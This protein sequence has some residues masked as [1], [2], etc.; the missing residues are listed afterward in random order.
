MHRRAVGIL[1]ISLSLAAVI[2][3]GCGQDEGDK[4]VARVGRVN[5]T[6]KELRQKLAE[7][8]PFTRQQFQGPEGTIDF[9][10]RLVDE[11]VLYQA[12]VKAGYEDD[13]EVKRTLEAIKRRS[14][15]QAYYKGEIES[16]VEVPEEDV[17]AYYDEHDEQFQREARI[18]FRHI[19]A[20]TRSQ[21]EEGRRRV[22]AGEDFASVARDMSTDGGSREAGGLMKSVNVGSALPSAGMDEDFIR[23]VYEDWRVGQVTE[24]LR[25]GNGW[26][27]V[28]LEERLEAGKKPLDEV[29]DNIVQSLM[30][31]KTREYYDSV[32]VEL[33]EQ[34]GAKVNED[35]FRTK[36]RTEEELFTLAQD[37]DDPLER[38]NYYSELVFNYPDGAHAAEAQF[39]IGF[40]HAEELQN[41]AAA[42]NAFRRVMDE[43]PDSDLVE[44]AQWMIENMGSEEPPFEE[45]DVLSTD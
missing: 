44:S 22:L 33:K 31:A 17:Q 5:I 11:E 9:L 27:V 3:S 10:K 21:A 19:M 35:A 20:P 4:V 43:Y 1:L 26:H 13:P 40:I 32:L 12:A 30:P 15:I 34:H 8:P 2:L 38:L 14:M 42:R 25:S 45:S 6:E 16:A 29:R 36:P 7:L 37:T 23:R 28:V 41:E 39:M 24:P 18:K